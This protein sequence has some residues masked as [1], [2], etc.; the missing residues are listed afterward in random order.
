MAKTTNSRA[1]NFVQQKT[2]FRA[3]NIY[4]EDHPSAYIVYSYGPHWP[5]F[6]YDKRAGE[7]LENTDKCSATTSKHRGQVHP[8]TDTRAMS[9]DD[10]QTRLAHLG[11]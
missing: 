5:L 7:W 3:N 11:C 10:L 9:L 2:E 1:R 6:V 4:A 8:L